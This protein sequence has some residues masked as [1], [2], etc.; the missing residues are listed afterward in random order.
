VADT[1]HQKIMC[2]DKVATTQYFFKKYCVVAG[3]IRWQIHATIYP[4]LAT[5]VAATYN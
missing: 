5:L 1:C 2:C 4:T 3:K